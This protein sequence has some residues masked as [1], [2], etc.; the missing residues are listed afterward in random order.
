M[1]SLGKWGALAGLAKG[2]S[3]AAQLTMLERIRANREKATATARKEERA[4]DREYRSEE[5]AMDRQD[6]NARLDK[7]LAAD[8]KSLDDKLASNEKLAGMKKPSTSVDKNSRQ[9]KVARL[10]DKL[11]K[12][13]IQQGKN[14]SVGEDNT[15]LDDIIERTAD[16]IAK[17]S[18]PTATIGG[19]SKFFTKQNSPNPSTPGI[20]RQENPLLPDVNNGSIN[21]EASNPMAGEQILPPFIGNER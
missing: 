19:Y 15:Q 5:K 9:Y 2:L 16:E 8:Q 11:D 1:S 21:A 6:S 17:L 12:Y 7:K 20:T 3:S 18:T 4:A 14:Q 13:R 10:Q